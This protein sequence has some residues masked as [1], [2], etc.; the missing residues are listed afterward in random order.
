MSEGF[1]SG[2]PETWNNID[3]DGDG[4]S[5]EILT[6]DEDEIPTHTGNG[7][8]A[9]ASYDYEE[10]EALEPD[11]YLITPAITIP[12]NLTAANMPLLSWWVAAQD[13]EYPADYY[14]VRISTTGNSAA[15]FSA[16]AVYAEIL[17][18]DEWTMHT[19]DLRN[20]IGQTI[21]IAFIHTNCSDEFIMKLDDIV[22]SYFD[23]PT[24]VTTPDVLDFGSVMIN[25]TSAS[26]PVNV[27]SAL[28]D[29]TISVSCE[30]PF[31]ISI[32]NNNF[33]TSQSMTANVSTSLFVRYEPTAEGTHEGV[34][35][36]TNGT[37]TA[38]ISV[39]G[40][41]VNC[42]NA[43]QLPF[44]EDFER[45]I[46]PCWTL[47]DADHDGMNWM[48][49]ND[50]YG[51]ESDG[52]YISYSYDEE[53]WEDLMPNDW[54]ITPRIAIPST[55][56]HINWW[57][58]AYDE[59]FPD[60]RYEVRVSTTLDFENSEV[61]YDEM[62]TTDEYGQR[63][64]NLTGFEGQEV[65][66]A[67]IHNTN[68]NLYEESYALV[69]DDIR[70]EEGVGIEENT[71]SPALSVY[72][73]PATQ[74]LN[75]KGEGFERCTVVNALGQTVV[76]EPMVNGELHLN[77]SHLSNGVYFVKC[78]GDGTVETVKIIKK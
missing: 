19:V 56:A 46:S 45:E 35:T 30:A 63:F 14:E 53:E 1:E 29:G 38:T 2:L 34:I 22:V 48:W 23:T 54:L 57:A 52:Y 47:R 24:I 28:L 11:N 61:I 12:A 17:S 74:M 7:C 69:I 31:S 42:D 5:W 20:Y 64:A 27:I 15:D 73:N 75:I 44:Y 10:E 43:L 40:N 3:H 77:I 60:N 51:H 32:N 55:G 21:Y 33:S 13:P 49:M 36:L 16:S 58:A 4:F 26:M 76:S 67:F 72:P 78:S 6:M 37:T 65:Y 62:L 41:A 39:N 66:I 25:T 9:S 18:T 71:C 70:I 8:I 50:G 59:G 68:T